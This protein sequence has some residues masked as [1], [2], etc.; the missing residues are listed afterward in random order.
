MKHLHIIWFMLLLPACHHS[1]ETWPSD[2]NGQEV[3]MYMKARSISETP[4]PSYSYRFFIFDSENKMTHYDV[5]PNGSNAE[6]MHLKLPPGN[7]TGYCV[8]NA[9]ESEY[10]EHPD[11]PAPEE[12]YLKAQATKTSH[13]EARDYLLG[14]SAFTVE[15]DK[16]NRATFNLQRK[17]SRLKVIIEQIPEWLNDL[18]INVSNIPQKMNLTGRFQ[19]NYTVSKAI[20]P[21]DENGVS[22]TDLLLFPP[23][24]TAGLSLSSDEMVFTSD[25]HPIDS[26]S[27]NRITEIKIIFQTP[28][29]LANVDIT[30]QIINWET[31]DRKEEDWEIDLPP[32]PCTGS[33]NG[34][35]LVHNGD[36]EGS[37]VNGVPEHWKLDAS[38]N[39]TPKT[40]ALETK[41]VQEGKQAVRIEGKTYIYQDIPVEGG[42][43]YQLHLWIDAPD[44]DAKWRCWGTWKQGSK[45]LN[46][47]LIRS[48]EYEKATSGYIDAYEGKLFRAPSTANKL[49]IE[50]RNYGEPVSGKGLFIDG[51]RVEAVD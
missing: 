33:G 4:S 17:V 47:E 10:W 27:P 25:E 38:N 51:V 18:K 41:N 23:E 24:K 16:P 13:E 49:R 14:K 46:S 26:I 50:V 22:E 12:T 7:Y 32:G 19:G 30:S 8:T 44:Q 35:N 11:N 20:T 40:A 37:F 6:N 5:N 43:C 34:I 28:P 9:T 36:F 3:A 31:P 42:R 48:P 21:P 1:M 2:E 39:T 45:D 15:A 29:D